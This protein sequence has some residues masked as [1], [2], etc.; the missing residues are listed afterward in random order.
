MKTNWHIGF[1]QAVIHKNAFL[2]DKNASSYNYSPVF[3]YHCDE[4]FFSKAHKQLTVITTLKNNKKIF[5]Y[6]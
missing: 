5:F 4:P 3:E 1:K 2:A 6:L